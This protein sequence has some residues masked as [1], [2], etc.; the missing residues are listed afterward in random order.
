[1]VGTISGFSGLVG[2]VGSF[3][4]PSRPTT[5]LHPS[6]ECYALFF[7]FASVLLSTASVFVIF[8]GRDKIQ[9]ERSLFL[10]LVLS[11]VLFCYLLS[12]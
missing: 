12:I 4:A 10:T 11:K 1:M 7:P 5:K 6:T 3:S 9:R 8:E 2:K